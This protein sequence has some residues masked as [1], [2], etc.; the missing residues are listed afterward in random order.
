M[1]HI[2]ARLALL[3]SL[4]NVHPYLMPE[5]TLF[6][7]TNLRLA[8]PDQISMTEFRELAAQLE[9]ERSVL[10]QRDEFQ[11]MKWKITDHGLAKLSEL[12]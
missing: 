10:S 11:R 6:A 9:E 4:S 5:P 12:R 2:P 3:Q 7:D 8:T 1:K